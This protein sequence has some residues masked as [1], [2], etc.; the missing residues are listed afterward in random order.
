M[1]LPSSLRCWLKKQPRVRFPVG[2]KLFLPKWKSKKLSTGTIAT[3]RWPVCSSPHTSNSQASIC[4]SYLYSKEGSNTS[5]YRDRRWEPKGLPNQS[6]NYTLPRSCS[7][8]NNNIDDAYKL[9]R[10]LSLKAVDCLLIKFPWNWI[11]TWMV[12]FKD[13]NW[14]R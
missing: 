14:A 6:L 5:L 13:K 10:V 7:S 2:A 1:V 11:P 4:R 3:K 12:F 8:N 9:W